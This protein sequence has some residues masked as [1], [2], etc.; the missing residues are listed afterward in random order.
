MGSTKFFTICQ[1]CVLHCKRR[2][3]R[4]CTA[5]GSNPCN[6][7]VVPRAF[8]GPQFHGHVEGLLDTWRGLLDSRASSPGFSEWPRAT[9]V[10]IVGDRSRWAFLFPED[11]CQDR[12]SKAQPFHLWAA[13]RHLV[14]IS[15]FGEE[16]C[17]P[18]RVPSHLFDP[19]GAF[20][21]C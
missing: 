19:R 14:D 21:Y 17:G 5:W 9:W 8:F 10:D 11:S 4:A 18:S 3:Q 16:P 13:N 1:H 15:G 20:V 12:P 6:T 2:A 7:K